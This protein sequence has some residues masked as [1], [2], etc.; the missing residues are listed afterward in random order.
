MKIKVLGCLGGKIPGQELTGFLVDE[1]LLI[2]AGSVASGLELGA[3]AK[4]KDLLISHTHLDHLYGLF[5]LLENRFYGE[6]NSPLTI[7]ASEEAVETLTREFLVEHLINLPAIN[8]LKKSVKIET[9]IPSQTRQIGNYQV[10]PVSVH[11]YA[12]ALGFFISDGRTEFLFTSDTGPTEEV[13]EKFQSRPQ[14]QLLITEVS[15]PNRLE[16]VAKVSRHLTPALLRVELE[17]ARPEGKEIFLYHLKPGYLDLLF[18]ELSEIQEYD[19]HLLKL[20]MEIDLGE[21]AQ[22]GKALVQE[23]AESVSGKVPKFDFGKDLDEQRQNLDREFGISFEPREIICEEGEAGKHLYIIQAGQVEVYRMILD[24]KKVLAILG[25]GDVFGEMSI[26]FSQPRSATVSAMTRVRAYAF[27]RPAFE[28]LVRENYGIAV[29]MIRMLAQRLQEA[30]VQIE[31]LLYRDNDSKVINTLVRAVEDE[32]I[33]TRTG[34]QLRLTPEQLALKTDLPAEEIK[35][36]LA[37]LIK[38][39]IV[40]FTEGLFQIPDLERLRRLLDYL[41]MKQEFEAPDKFDL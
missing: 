23:R 4:I 7:Y 39:K 24:K 37:R 40:I 9:L 6:V 30:D 26:F 35:K 31:N 8:H 15:F 38:N 27:D 19:L 1:D 34:H 21:M 14:C 41:E 29:K 11:H 25:P 28:Q 36:L 32:G 22:K 18:Q 3:Q 2:D 13:W 5:Y 12:G 20:G 10:E 17:K 16:E 33:K